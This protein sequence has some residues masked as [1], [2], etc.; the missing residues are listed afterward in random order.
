[1]AQNDTLLLDQV[2]SDK[3]STI[4]PHLAD[5]E[6]FE[7]FVANE[8]LKPYDLSES[9]LMDGI[10]RGGNDGGIDAAYIFLNDELITADFQ[11]ENVKSQNPIIKAV[12]IQAKQR[13]GFEEQAITK[14]TSTMHDLL[15]FNA[16][17]QDH[18]QRYNSGLLSI[19]EVYHTV[20][21]QLSPRFPTHEFEFY[22]ATKGDTLQ[23]HPNVRSRVPML[24]GIVR[25]FLPNARCTFRFLGASELLQ[26]AREQSVGTLDLKMTHT[27]NTN[28]A[29]LVCLVTLSDYFRFISDESGIRRQAIFDANVREHERDA[30]VNRAI[31]KTLASPNEAID[32]WWL[33]NGITIIASQASRVGN[34]VTLSNPK[35]VNGL[36][37][38]Q[39]ISAY[40]AL[41]P[42]VRDERLL[43]AKIIVT[44]DED[45]FTQIITANNSQTS[46]P[47][48]S[49]H[50]GE[51]I[52][53]D[54]EQDFKFNGLL[55]ERQKNRYKNMGKPWGKIVTIPYLA[56]AIMAI[57][58]RE[59]NN[60]RARPATL[61]KSPDA[62]A[63]IFSLDYDIRVYRKCAILMKKVED[64]LRKQAPEEQ[65]R[66]RTN[67]RYHLAMLVSSVVLRSTS[68]SSSDI[69]EKRAFE[70]VD[71]DL[72]QICARELWNAYDDERTRRQQSGDKVAKNRDFDQ[73]VLSLA[74]DIIQRG[75]SPENII[76]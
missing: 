11:P 32:F 76:V 26:L 29:S 59:P 73:R 38:S 65:Y 68:Y 2:L 47:P 9:E 52:H 14:I 45:T 6:F 37:T 49:L 58:L 24:E 50:A 63:R 43:L 46:I 12:F 54:I 8:I 21:T 34:T 69:V 56:Q 53:K 4:A 75:H 3:H 16:S 25:R 42:G 40:C 18:R 60:A 74:E 1:M 71:S 33:N 30:E 62:Y 67:L 55:Y 70:E 41:N 17:L 23:L 28:E 31:R 35:V 48:H 51:Q 27:L 61:I 7:L 15:D 57:V 22:Y 66:E 20:V 72:I 64:Y 5:S 44:D 39:E 13:N 10:V 36:Q 19:M